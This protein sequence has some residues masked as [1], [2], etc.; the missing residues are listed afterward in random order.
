MKLPLSPLHPWNHTLYL[1]LTL[2]PLL[3]YTLKP[4]PK[5]ESHLSTKHHDWRGDEEL[6]HEDYITLCVCVC[7]LMDITYGKVIRQIKLKFLNETNS[8]NVSTELYL[9]LLTDKFK[10]KILSKSWGWMLLMLWIEMYRH[11]I[12]RLFTS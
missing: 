11:F 10:F 3:N 2:H 7:M 4:I 8:S 12:C 6:Y 1:S 5:P 9:M